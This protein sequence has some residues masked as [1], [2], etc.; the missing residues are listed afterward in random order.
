MSN[1]DHARRIR[2]SENYGRLPLSFE[3]N[4]GQQDPQVQFLSRGRGYNLFL[5]PQEAVLALTKPEAT[6]STVVR[7]RL[8]GANPAAML[9]GEQ[10]LPGKA[11]YFIGNDS[12]K[13]RT[14]VP[15][16]ARV[17]YANLYPGIDLVYYGNQRQLE[18]DFVVAPGADPAP[19][20]MGIAG[21]QK[22]SVDVEGRLVVQTNSGEVRWDKPRIYQEVNGKRREVNGRYAL[23]GKH[24][25]RFE[26]AAYDKSK[27]LVI[28]PTLV[29]STYLAGSGDDRTGGIAVDN[30]GNAYIAGRTTSSNF[31]ATPGAF[32]T[33]N[34]S[35][36]AF[37]TKLNPSGT[38]ALYSTYLGGT[39][40]NSTFPDFAA[41][42][43]VDS[44][45]NAYVTGQ[46]ASSNFPVTAGAY[47]TTWRGGFAFCCGVGDA[48]VTKLSPTGSSLVWSTFIG[49]SGFDHAFGIALDSSNNVYVAGQTQS[50][51]FPITAG[52]FQTS[53]AGSFGCGGNTSN[54]FAAE[55]NASGTALVWSTYLGGGGFDQANGIAVDSAGNAYVTG[56]SGST[57]FPTTMGSYQP[58]HNGGNCSYDAFVTKLTPTGAAVYSTN[59][60]GAGDD[61]GNAITVDSSGNAYVIG[62]TPSID[63]P[64]T[65]GVCQMA[66]GGSTDTFVTRLNSTGSALV[67][68]TYLG[69]SGDD[70]GH[71]IALDTNQNVYVAGGTTSMNFPT[72][73][74]AFQTTHHNSNGSYEMYLTMLTPGAASLIYSTYFG[75]S[76]G[77]TFVE[78]NTLA[79][80]TAS[81]V[82]IAGTTTASDLP[83]TAGAFQ[84]TYHGGL[85]AF[86]AKFNSICTDGSWSAVASL[87]VANV[88]PMAAELNGLLYV[89]GGSNWSCG[90]Y[91]S[92]NSYDP[93][94]NTWT[95]HASMPT[96]RS[97]GAAGVINGKIYV[98]G[99]D[100]TCGVRSNANEAYDPTTN[101][102]TVL[103]PRPV[104]A[105]EAAGGVINGKLYV[106]GGIDNAN[107]YLTRNDIY[108]S[109]T[110][111][112][113]SG[114]P[115]PNVQRS[116][117]GAVVNGLLYVIGGEDVNGGVINLVEAYDPITDTWSTKA[118]LPVALGYS[119]GMATVFNGRIYVC[120]GA[121]NSG[122]SSAVYVY[123]A[124]S[125]S[126]S[127]V[128]PMPN[129]RQSLGTASVQ[130]KLYALGGYDGSPI[131]AEVDAFTPNCAP[132]PTPVPTVTP[133][134]TAT[135][136]ATFTPTPTATATFTPTPTATF[137]PTATPTF[138]PTP[139]PTAEAT[140]A[141]PPSGLISW[142][143][144]DGN[145]NDIVDGN[146]GTLQGGATFGSG[147][148]GQAFSFNG[149]TQYVRVKQGPIIGSAANFTVD[150]WVK[151][152]GGGGDGQQQV[153]CEGS[154]N[155]IINL[156]LV[157]SGNVAY[158]VFQTLSDH[159]RNVTA[160]IPINPNEWHHIAGVLQQGVGGV[161]YVDGQSA[162]NNP[163]MGP[164]SQ[165]TAETDIGRFAGN[166]GSRYLSG[167]ADE[168]QVFSRALSASEI[169]AIYNAGTSGQCKST[170]SPTPTS[171]P[172]A[173]ATATA[174]FTP[175]ATPTAT[176]TSTSTPTPT[177]TPTPVHNYVAQVQPPINADGTS[178]FTVKRGV[179]PVKFTLTDNGS[180]TCDLP[181]ATI[182][183]TRTAGGTIGEVNES[184]YSGFA[185]QGPNFRIDGCQYVYN[186]NSTALGV[187]TY[188]VD[189]KINNQVVGSAVFQLR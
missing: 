56:S 22:I 79:L 125:D 178:V 112:W 146:N 166:G 44:A 96:A 10:E 53:Y 52:A 148:V 28:D 170:P 57:N 5:T 107:N 115:I 82:Y 183:V 139:T 185:D 65:N 126:W 113:T 2:L 25:V 97:T 177:P 162:G 123:D 34:R 64:T 6:E 50:T 130:G 13:W 1:A 24:E 174:T 48:F 131:T 87:P 14:S 155:D 35:V 3:T 100:A 66:L 149:S 116:A 143:P 32:Q 67:W 106:I 91:N 156:M 109:V 105:T 167:L 90:T 127:S 142:W 8:V 184:L 153:Y 26:V 176:A 21:A 37:V 110:N 111:A 189:I 122:P 42:V 49:G 129:A 36:N 163:D 98:V 188:R 150:A 80:D 164:G 114:A 74:D 73:A 158:P 4:E 145:A 88:G 140:C 39:G 12:A 89:A 144:A 182:V 187:G 172:T 29:Y 108:D 15:T 117:G 141:P 84:T 173:T 94:T 23:H 86:V 134:A 102:W 19:I 61:F 124:G 180:S 46:A 63:F 16:Y 62:S 152:D 20:R 157:K 51:N 47:Q 154:F 45:G 175:S 92:L 133:V 132:S 93:S 69:G 121:S 101:T 168:V 60:G 43:A 120:G 118:P 161:L 171:T 68:S 70:V 119:P 31:P 83:V 103:A 128:T 179:V 72:T 40:G 33:T 58:A 169:Q 160:S 165:G 151:W 54:G 71:G 181:P 136:T 78:L 138:T 7:V 27:S 38:T 95:P 159:W 41:A 77:D 186:L 147:Q 76:N 104:A 17:R 11:N 99:G 81:N 55:L 18:Y 85:D 75:G 137:T 30:A 59:L 135:A 9:T